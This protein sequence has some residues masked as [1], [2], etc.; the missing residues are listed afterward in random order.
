MESPI[1]AMMGFS[2]GLRRAVSFVPA[3]RFMQMNEAHEKMLRERPMQEIEVR[4]PELC[5]VRLYAPQCIWSTGLA[6]R[7]EKELGPSAELFYSMT[8]EYFDRLGDK[9][10]KFMAEY[11]GPEL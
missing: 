5:A 8:K 1:G 10:E 7:P 9:M 4:S 3:H 2:A 11:F 6:C